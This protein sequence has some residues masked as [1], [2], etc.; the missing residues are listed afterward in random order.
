MFYREVALK[1]SYYFDYSGG[2]FCLFLLCLFAAFAGYLSQNHP[3]MR[4][5]MLLVFFVSVSI[6]TFIMTFINFPLG[7]FPAFAHH[8]VQL[9]FLLAMIFDTVNGTSVTASLLCISVIA[10]GVYVPLFFLGR[11]TLEVI[12]DGHSPSR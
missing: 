12:A 2:F 11:N 1:K 9:V 3:E 5:W 7:K 8:T 6:P 10:F 4:V